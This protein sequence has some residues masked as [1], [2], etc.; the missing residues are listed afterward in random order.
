MLRLS[1]NAD[2]SAEKFSDLL[3]RN[4]NEGGH[5]CQQLADLACNGLCARWRACATSR[6][7]RSPPLAAAAA[8][9]CASGAGRLPH[10][11]LRRAAEGVPAA[12]LAAGG[13]LTPAGAERAVSD[14]LTAWA[15]WAA[16]LHWAHAAAR[17]IGLGHS[18]GACRLCA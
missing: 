7:S 13:L 6:R 1:C 2:R 8:A 16:A 18:A 14:G 15:G 4:E 10:G 17:V 5:A 3:Q 9:A 11:A 12:V